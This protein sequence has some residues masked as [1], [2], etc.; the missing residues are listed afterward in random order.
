[1]E[2]IVC[3]CVYVIIIQVG[4][5][6]QCCQTAQSQGSTKEGYLI[7][8]HVSGQDQ[9]RFPRDVM[10]INCWNKSKIHPIRKEE[11]DTVGRDNTNKCKK[12]CPNWHIPEFN[13]AKRTFLSIFLSFF[14]YSS[15]SLFFPFILT[16]GPTLPEIL[17]PK[18]EEL[19][20]YKNSN[21]K[22]SSEWYKSQIFTLEWI[23]I[24]PA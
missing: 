17:S 23:K 19:S 8:I 6:Y 16:A 11:M 13:M 12:E 4:K 3:V 2:E 10:R 9:G 22:H 18:K 5:N 21:H 20:Y 15:F 24:G 1:M 14:F 7:Q